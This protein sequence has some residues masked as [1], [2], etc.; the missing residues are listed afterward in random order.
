[1][2]IVSA[3]NWGW[4][5]IRPREPERLLD[6]SVIPNLYGSTGYRAVGNVLSG[7]IYPDI[8]DQLTLSAYQRSKGGFADIHQATWRRGG[9]ET[10]VAIKVLRVPHN[11]S[12]ELGFVRKRICRELRI[13]SKLKHE[14]ILPL[15]GVAIGFN[16]I[17]DGMYG[18]VCMWA[19]NGDLCQYLID[20]SDLPLQHR[21]D[22]LLQISDALRYLHGNNVVHG[23]LT[24][25][26]VLV[27]NEG[28]TLLCDFGVSL[29]VGDINDPFYETSSQQK[30][31]IPW[32][33]PEILFPGDV[34]P[35]RPTK[36]S[37]IYSFGS[38]MLQILTGQAPYNRQISTQIAVYINRCKRDTAHPQRPAR[39]SFISDDLWAFMKQCWRSIPEE[40]LCAESV[41][42]FLCEYEYGI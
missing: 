40:R 14:H 17:P 34:S 11:N 26:N 10:K 39:P 42:N 30:Y 15:Y 31:N 2:V 41:Y 27:D 19:E 3:V 38:V 36:F 25:V 35:A 1:M 37:D 8:S 22:M 28:N 6:K 9:G 33:A 32:S 29:I 12:K 16:I 23:D 13:W 18:M 4:R 24:G 5:D 21:L 7:D 20:N